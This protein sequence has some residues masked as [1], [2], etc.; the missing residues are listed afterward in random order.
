MPIANAKDLKIYLGDMEVKSLEI[1][2]ETVPIYKHEDLV[3]SWA[4]FMSSLR[5]P[6]EFTINFD[7]SNAYWDFW[8]ELF[9]R[10]FYR[11]PKWVMQAVL[12]FAFVILVLV[13]L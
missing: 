9:E 1:L 12:L 11:Y 2:G 5:K 8:E 4:L 10:P 7:M 13:L 6:M 3:D